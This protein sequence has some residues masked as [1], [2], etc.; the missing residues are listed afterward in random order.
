MNCAN[1]LGILPGCVKI[2]YI[3]KIIRFLNNI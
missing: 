1:D 2:D 3:T